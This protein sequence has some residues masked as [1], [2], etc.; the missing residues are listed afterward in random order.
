M[1]EIPLPREYSLV[2]GRGR[3][4]VF[5]DEQCRELAARYR[6]DEKLTVAVL[7][8]EQHCSHQT[9]RGVLIRGGVTLDDFREHQ[10][11]GV[12]GGHAG[13]A[14]HAQA[15]A[16]CARIV[17][18][19]DA[20]RSCREIMDATGFTEMWV[21]RVLRDNGRRY[22]RLKPPAPS[23]RC[24]CGV[25]LSEPGGNGVHCA[26]CVEEERA[27]VVPAYKCGKVAAAA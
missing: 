13:R 17:A 11:R 26:F 4:R 22:A 19:F 20:G 27:G 3:P 5:S 15:E 8:R 1:S 16:R 6:A 18:L 14:L 25:L 12:C 23:K 21:R 2:F 7:T 10:N 24:A 9:L